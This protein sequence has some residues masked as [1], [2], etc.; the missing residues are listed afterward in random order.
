MKKTKIV[1]TLGPA[2]ADNAV[3]KNLFLSGLDVARINFS[4]GTHQE[5]QVTIDNFKK[6]RTETGLP[7]PLMLD[8]K[9]PEIRVKT[10]ENG[11]VDLVT[12]QSFTFTTRDIVGSDQEV[13]IT[14]KHLP[15]VV[16]SGDAILIDDGLIECRVKGTTA[17]DIACEVLNGGT[18][19]NRKSINLPGI[20]VGMPYISQSDIDDICFGI[21]NEFDFIA[22]SFT[23]GAED[24]TKLKKVL[25]DHGG[26]E[27]KIIA[28]IENQEGV[29]NIDNILR[30]SDG[31]M[32]A[33][34][35]MGVEV[36]LE[37][38]PAIQKMLI[39]KCYRAGKM[40]ITATQMLESM[41]HNPRPTRAEITDIANAI[42]DGTSAIM[43]SG[44]TAIGSYPELAVQTMAKI[45]LR[46]ENTINYVKR[47]VNAE[48]P[49]S[50]NVTDAISHATCT[51][52]HDLGAAAILTVTKTGTTARMISKFRPLCP[53]IAATPSERTCRQMNLSWG[54]LPFLCQE[55]TTTDELF[56]VAEQISIDSGVVHNGD[57]VVITAGVPV[58]VSGYTN[59]LKVQ[60]IGNVLVQGN[61]MNDLVSYGNLCVAKDSRHAQKT[62]KDG[63]I[64]VM[65]NTCNEV[66][67]LLGHASGLVI[68]EEGQNS[69]GAIA[70]MALH[71]PVI[72]GAKHATTVLKSGTTVTIDSKQ[73]FIYNGIVESE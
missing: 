33:R 4:H 12:G 22:A 3:L 5:H 7:V 2:T 6:V 25:H 54:V 36:P 21:E 18:V 28:K 24:I 69:H 42:Y 45:A 1:C 23:R 19:K 60:L 37:D 14:Y 30:V 11:S 66:L 20:S 32:V 47:F 56:D 53:I 68:E 49:L 63:D 16:K 41:I 55:K 13:A 44:E 39:K 71:I 65:K 70:G 27:I 29:N 67:D 15:T 46:T 38:L 57:L 43:L 51:T 59:I 10:F 9:G 64:L 31:I 26:K 72:I 48:P 50:P 34:G 8:T 17:T 58:G 40:A 35:D 73:G 62:F 61:G 52:A